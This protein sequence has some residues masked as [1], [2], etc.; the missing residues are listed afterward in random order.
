MLF[1]VEVLVSKLSD[2]VAVFIRWQFNIYID[3]L[4]WFRKFSVTINYQQMCILARTFLDKTSWT[5]CINCH[6][7]N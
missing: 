5:Q 1:Q 3:L 7:V 4:L 6:L 2:F